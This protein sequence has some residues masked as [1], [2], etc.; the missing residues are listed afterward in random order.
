ML[1]L[2]VGSEKQ[3]SAN[4][5]VRW[6]VGRGELKKLERVKHPYILLSVWHSG[7]KREVERVLVPLERAMTY[8]QFQ[9]AGRHIVRAAIVF[10][11]EGEYEPDYFGRKFYE[12]SAKRGPDQFV[13]YVTEPTGELDEQRIELRACLVGDLL[14]EVNVEVSADFF[15]KDPPQW[16]EQWVNLVYEY[17]PRDQC[18]FRRRFLFAFTLQ[19]VVLAVVVPFMVLVRV[20]YAL[21]ALAWGRNDI[22]WR[23]VFGLDTY[24]AGDICRDVD[25]FRDFF[26][27]TGNF[28][29]YGKKPDGTLQ[30]RSPFWLFLHPAF[31]LP[32]GTFFLSGSH[33]IE[34]TYPTVSSLYLSPARGFGFLGRRGDVLG[35][36]VR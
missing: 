18:A 33:Q 27:P 3:G 20:A 31:W 14:A 16:L 10:P 7:V 19:P 17:P 15:A 21:V 22:V 24:G 12:L 30:E 35:C 13:C 36:S 32:L 4:I 26:C 34:L 23:A 9:R 25:G 8:L 1:K 11:R 6:T 28:Y 2:V 5:A 29:L